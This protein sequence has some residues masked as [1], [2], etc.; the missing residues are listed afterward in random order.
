MTRQPL[1]ARRA[2]ALLGT[3]VSATSPVAGGDT[4]TSTRLRLADGRNALMK[5]QPGAPPGSSR[6][7]RGGC[8][9]SPR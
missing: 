5:T 3:A 7:R 9:G 1:L 8:A 2:E 6:P 4:S